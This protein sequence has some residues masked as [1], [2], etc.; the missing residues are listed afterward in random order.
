[1]AVALW[2]DQLAAWNAHLGLVLIFYPVGLGLLWCL[3]ALLWSWRW[4]RAERWC[5][6]PPGAEAGP[7]VSVL[8]PCF[9]EGPQLAETLRAALALHWGD[10]EVIAINDGS[11]DDTGPQLEAW[12]AHHPR[13]RVVHLAS[14]QG[15]ALALKAGALLA[16]HELLVCID[17]DA[18]LDP[19]AIGWMVRHFQADPGLAAV[20]GN[21]R[22]RNRSSLLG[23]LQ[24]GEFSM[25]V[26]LIKRAQSLLGCL[27]CVSG[28]IGCFRRQALYAVDGWDPR[29]LTEDIDLTWRL[30][31]AG[32]RVRYEP[33]ALVWILMPETLSGLWRQR[34]RWARGG[35]EVLRAN[36]DLLRRPRLWRL[37][38]LLLEPLASLLWAHLL[39]LSLLLG[40]LQ[41]YRSGLHPAL[42]L[43]QGLGQLLLLVCLLQFAISFWLDRPYDVG[44]GRIA[45]WMIWF[46]ALYWLLS[47][48]ASLAACWQGQPR[49]AAQRAR[50]LSPDRGLRS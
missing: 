31:R 18:L 21:P 48:L 3:L 14:N 4:E 42:L 49:R 26:G 13:L 20:T 43:P 8:I 39:V 28:V 46:P 45:F 2:L 33:H 38:P 12:A 23:R 30:Q 29:R 6:Q 7:P 24:V 37:L 27:F 36:L 11:S 15:K 40:L 25:I 1:M 47:L 9:N 19:W 5:A 35:L 17:A 16:R 41:A 10:W 44:L 32:W 50:W 34:L 22:I